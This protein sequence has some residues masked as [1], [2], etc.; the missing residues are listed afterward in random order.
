MMLHDFLVENEFV[1]SQTDNCIY[2]KLSEK[3][4]VILLALV[5]NIVVAASN[6]QCV[7]EVKGKLKYQFKMKDLEQPSHFIGIDFTQTAGT[8]KMN[9]S[10]Y[11][12]KILERFG[13][14]ECKSRATP[15]EVK[16]DLMIVLLFHGKPRSCKMLHCQRVRQSIWCWQPQSISSLPHTVVEGHGSQFSGCIK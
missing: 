10:R 3:E 7:N 5:D 11:I 6:E 1:Q 12:G 16:C 8:V 4:K 14:S 9:Q 13:M 15:S 2:T